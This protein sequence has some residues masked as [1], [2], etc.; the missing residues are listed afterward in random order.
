MKSQQ[1]GPNPSLVRVTSDGA[2]LYVG[3]QNSSS[4]TRLQ[5]PGL[6]A[7]MT[8]PLGADAVS[9]PITA[10]DIEPAPGAPQTVA[11]AGSNGEAIVFDN[12]VVRPNAHV[13]SI[14]GNTLS[15]LQWGS[16]PSV[17]YGSGTHVGTQP[18]DFTIMNVD[19]SGVSLKE[20][21]PGALQNLSTVG[22]FGNDIHYD[23]G[24]RLLY[25]DD[26]A[27][28]DPTNAAFKGGYNSWG[29]VIPDSSLN[30]VF[31]LG[32][33]FV[34]PGYPL[35]SWTNGFGLSSYNQR[36]FGFISSFKLPPIPYSGGAGQPVSFVRCGGSC[37]A[38]ATNSATYPDFAN[39]GMLYILNDSAFVKAA[40]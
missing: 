20:N 9:G 14:S 37:L 19:A 6:S 33:T 32:L 23:G 30:T 8:W 11:I 1:V 4:I 38:F 5:L 24:T 7:P 40:P 26:G 29:F 18:W 16:A 31:V 36:T 34:P 17:L 3:Y 22:S 35:Q 12:S 25:V 21:D 13:P 27:V 10:S 39:P 15:S 28:V 2:Y